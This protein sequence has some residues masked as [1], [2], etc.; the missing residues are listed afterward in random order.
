MKLIVDGPVQGE[1]CKRQSL[2]GVRLQGHCPHCGGENEFDLGDDSALYCPKLEEPYVVNMLCV[3]CT[4]EFHMGTIRL[5]LT[6][7]SVEYER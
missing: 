2:Q 4:Q 7:Q 1:L 6:V 3:V 5:T